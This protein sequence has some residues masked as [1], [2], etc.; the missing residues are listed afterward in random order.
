MAYTDSDAATRL[1]AVRAAIGSILSGNQ[2]YSIGDRTFRKG[3]LA[4]LRA[5]EKDLV[6][7]VAQSN[8]RA[9]RVVRASFRGLH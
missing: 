4:Q 9:P 3:D 1:A 2:S 5:M 8:R 7:Q 6:A